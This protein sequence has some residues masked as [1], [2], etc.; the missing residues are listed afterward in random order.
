[1]SGYTQTIDN[2]VYHAINTLRSQND[3]HWMLLDEIV[4]ECAST[5]NVPLD[6]VYADY[7]V[8]LRK[9]LLLLIYDV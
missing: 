7:T 1:M 6:T 9:Q 2:L 5:Y 8:E 4:H 3:E